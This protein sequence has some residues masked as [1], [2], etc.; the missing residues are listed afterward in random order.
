MYIH[1]VK[2]RLTRNPVYFVTQIFE[3]AF[4][5]QPGFTRGEK[6][7]APEAECLF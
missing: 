6:L 5:A 2:K 7:V 3:Y 4:T 1:T